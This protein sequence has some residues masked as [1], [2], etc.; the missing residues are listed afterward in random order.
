MTKDEWGE[1]LRKQT[2]EIRE[3]LDR[4]ALLPSHLRDK[5]VLVR[6]YC[7][8]CSK[9]CLEVVRTRRWRVVRARGSQPDGWTPQLPDGF[10]NLPMKDQGEGH[11]SCPRRTSAPNPPR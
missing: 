8:H 11:G 9:P 1:A 2:Q 3:D 7:P 6:Y 5:R 10:E 4:L